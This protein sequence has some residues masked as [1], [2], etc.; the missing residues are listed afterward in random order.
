MATGNTDVDKLKEDLASLRSDVRQLADSLK[1]TSASHL[2]SGADS[3]RASADR[4]R[5]Q[6]RE[7]A[8]S[9]ESE[10]EA[11]PLTSVFT[12]FGIGF[13]LGKLLD[14]R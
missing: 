1:S 7:A 3:A 8:R 11:H 4:F 13:V 6:A 10:I 14:R 2:R 12:A 9:A 5:G